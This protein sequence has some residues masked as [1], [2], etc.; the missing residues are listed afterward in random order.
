MYIL[1]SSFMLGGKGCTF[2]CV[3]L[4]STQDADS[5]LMVNALI[6]CSR[7]PREG[8]PPK[9]RVKTTVADANAF[10]AVGGQRL[11]RD[12]VLGC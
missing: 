4:K 3:L 2:D 5:V 8:P 10:T 9:I 11:V 1:L 6:L 12:G 7:A